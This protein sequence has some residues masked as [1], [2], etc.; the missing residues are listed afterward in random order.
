MNRPSRKNPISVI[1][2]LVGQFHGEAGGR[3]H[4]GQ[5]RNAG[6]QG[7][8]H[9]FKAGP[10]ADQ[11]AAVGQRNPPGE[12]LRADQFID[13]VVPADILAEREHLAGRVEERGRVQ[14]AGLIE[15]GLG[16]PQPLGQAVN[17]RGEIR[18]SASANGATFPIAR[19]S[20]DVFPHTPQLDVV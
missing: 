14:P 1:L 6:H 13:G 19:A 3:P 8:L 17:R 18:G 2:N 12:E 15:D 20:S 7:L 16:P 9:Q 11:D 5:Q 10:A 4:G